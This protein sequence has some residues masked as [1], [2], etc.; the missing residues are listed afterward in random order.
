MTG[1]KGPAI[2]DTNP[3]NPLKRWWPAALVLLFLLGGGCFVLVQLLKGPKRNITPYVTE[4]RIGSLAGVIT[5]SGEIEAVQ[6]VNVSPKRQGQLLEL[7]VD[8]GDQVTAGQPLARMDPSDIRNRQEE[9]KA[10][11][12]SAQVDLNRS[13]SEY[14]RRQKL[15]SQ[16]AL[17]GD[18]L[19]RFKASFENS[20]AAFIAAKQRLAQRAV[21][22]GDLVVRAPFSGTITNRYADPG[23]YVTPTTAASA[24]AGAT[25]SS[26]VELA[27]GLQVNAK[28]PESDIGRITLGQAAK[29]RVDAFPD[30]RFTA[31]VN[32][33]SPRTEKSSN[34]TTVK[35][36]LD[37]LNP[38]PDTLR[39]GMTADIDFDAGR[40]MPKPLVPTV[41]IVTENGKPG[42]LLPGPGSQPRFRE[43]TLGSSS[44]RNTQ[45]LSG[46]KAGE[47]VFIDLPPWTKK[48]KEN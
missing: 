11:L 7:Y 23:S 24:T 8:E 48:R 30:Q 41:A 25:S 39:I 38:P 40:L 22:S 13:R 15:F 42:L 18:D 4:V 44:G 34:V 46:V 43:V 9:L 14:E 2:A 27:S 10:Q 5:A 21:E 1:V 35:V 31:R 37:L 28:V 17:S 32:R 45:I 36:E 12:A 19:T 29:V 16:G 26:I 33:I 3:P 6:R 20:Q 47:Q